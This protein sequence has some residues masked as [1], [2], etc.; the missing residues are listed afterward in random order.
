MQ[1]D[2]S[3]A[4][5]YILYVYTVIET[6]V[7]SKKAERILS[8][9]ERDAFAVYISKNPKAGVV[10]RGSGGVRKVRWALEG[11]GK[12]GGVRVMYFNRLEKGEIWLLTLYAKSERSSVPPGELRLLKEV[13]DHGR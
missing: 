6:P 1:V 3:T 9:D 10:V 5:P 13:I 8:E 12:S 7:Y 2:V 4:M 11:G